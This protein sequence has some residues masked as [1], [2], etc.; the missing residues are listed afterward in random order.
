MPE[1][2]V[3]RRATHTK[4]RCNRFINLVDRPKCIK[5]LDVATD[6][7]TFC[8]STRDKGAEALNDNGDKIGSLVEVAGGEEVWEYDS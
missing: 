1:V 4:W 2:T 3:T 8:G 7:C 5:E 6:K